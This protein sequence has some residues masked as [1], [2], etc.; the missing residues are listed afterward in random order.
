MIQTKIVQGNLLYHAAHGLCRVKQLTRQIEAGKEV[1]FYALEPSSANKTKV[2]FIIPAVNVQASGFHSLV[3]TMEAKGILK[4][5]GDGNSAPLAEGSEYEAS[6]LAK[7]IFSF[8]RVDRTV[9]DLKNRRRM[10]RSVHGLVGEL[11]VVLKM[12]LNETVRIIRKNL[13]DASKINPL[14]M[15]ALDHAVEN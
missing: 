7:E 3:S 4:Y 6:Y 8:S 9:K 10:E 2:R 14:V 5:L 15:S 13:G 12:T 1:L 11:A